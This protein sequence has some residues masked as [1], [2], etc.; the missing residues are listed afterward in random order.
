MRAVEVDMKLFR[1]VPFLIFVVFS[2][3]LSA[4]IDNE[5]VSIESAFQGTD[6]V[7]AQDGFVG[8]GRPDAFVGTTEIYRRSSSSARASSSSRLT[9]PTA[10]PRAAVSTAQRQIGRLPGASTL[11]NVN[12]QAIRSSTSLDSGI[13]FPTIQTP[14]S[15]LETQLTRIQG[16]QDSQITFTS[17]PTG[18]TAVLTGTVASDRE[19]RVAQLYLLMEPGINRV[20]NRL[21]VR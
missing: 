9:T 11:G 7:A 12:A 14:I 6:N 16:I 15:T 13:V 1:I 10:R 4:Q 3:S 2:V 21:E 8:S 17:S 5:G 18:A 20:E 19:R